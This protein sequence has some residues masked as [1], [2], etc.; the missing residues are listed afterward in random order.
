MKKHLLVLILS[1]L[2]VLTG[3]QFGAPPSAA[4]ETTS[5]EIKPVNFAIPANNKPTPI[6]IKVPTGDNSGL[7]EIGY[8]FWLKGS[9]TSPE[10]FNFGHLHSNWPSIAG[11]VDN[12]FGHCST[13]AR[14]RFLGKYKQISIKNNIYI[15]INKFPFL[16]ALWLG[17]SGR[18]GKKPYYHFVSNQKNNGNA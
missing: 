16:I 10:Y 7:Q 12:K 2:L 18:N 4:D 14:H 11:V 17:N 15:Q 13:A 3:A 1:T 5:A 8:S 6:D 9:Y